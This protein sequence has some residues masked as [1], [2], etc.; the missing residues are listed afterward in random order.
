[1]EVWAAEQRALNLRPAQLVQVKRAYSGNVYFEYKDFAQLPV[2]RMH[3]FEALNVQLLYNIDSSDN[4]TLMVETITK[5]IQTGNIKNV[6]ASWNEFLARLTKLPSKGLMCQMAALFMIRHD[7]NP[8]ELNPQIQN[9]KIT[10][11][12]QENQLHFPEKS[13]FLPE[14][15]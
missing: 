11:G 1:M 8:H 12:Q 14:K 2:E 10:E 7:E 9:E 5:S 15:L 13:R 6:Q 4:F 3:E